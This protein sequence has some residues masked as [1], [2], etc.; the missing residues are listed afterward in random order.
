MLAAVHEGDSLLKE[1]AR[2][3]ESI[4]LSSLWTIN[5]HLTREHVVLQII[6]SLV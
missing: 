2:Y 3:I 6:S 5:M 4:L 1:T